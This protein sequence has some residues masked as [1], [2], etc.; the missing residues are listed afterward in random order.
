MGEMATLSLLASYDD[1]I[2]CTN[3]L[4][5]S[6]CEA[7]FMRFALGQLECQRKWLAAENECKRLQ[8][9]LEAA[10]NSRTDL[11]KKLLLARRFLDG[12]KK[13]RYATEQELAAVEKQLGMVRDLVLG[14]DSK[15]PINNETKEKLAFLNHTNRSRSSAVY[16]IGNRESNGKRL[17]T[18][19]EDLDYTGSLLSDLSYSRSDDDLD[20]SLTRSGRPWKKH[21][22]SMPGE[23]PIAAKRRCSNTKSVQLDGMAASPGEQLVATTTVTLSREGPIKASARIE[24]TPHDQK[25]FETPEVPH[26]IEIQPTA[27]PKSSSGESGES[28]ESMIGVPGIGNLQAARSPF[29]SGFTLGKDNINNRG[30]VFAQK[31]IIRPE[32]C[33]PCGKKIKFGKLAAKCRDCRACCHLEC[34]DQLPMPCV[35]VTSTPTR[36]GYVGVISDFTP[37]VAPMIPALIL[38]CIKEIEQR[39]LTEIGLY[40]IPGS[41]RDVKQLKEKFLRSRGAPN[42]TGVEVHVLCGTIKDF[43]RSLREP[44]VT[45]SLWADFV[46]CLEP[47]DLVDRKA[48]LYQVISELPQPNRDTL[49]YLILHLQRI[50]E[51]PECKMPALNL[52]KIFG[53]TLVGY[54]CS[55]PEPMAM[56]NETRQ[57][58]GV[59][60]LMLS[61][62]SSYWASFVNV[63]S[64]YFTQQTPEVHRTPSVDALSHQSSATRGFF[65]PLGSRSFKNR[66]KKYFSKYPEA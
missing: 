4:T 13:K 57:A 62:E 46:R 22:Y 8:Q 31:T 30:H 35:P 24:T 40:R 18:I 43:L 19:T 53:P 34:K 28:E 63:D 56:V 50:S 2:R 32:T 42:L 41:E 36:K 44:L 60:E 37:V 38:H 59:V 21:R 9:E 29:V 66:N 16:S 39:G 17:N 61:T 48:L 45:Q 65:T 20:L 33:E 47:S 52:A 14:D 3:V 12:E 6:G 64:G 15:I 10:N 5:E 25:Y 1:L 7:E 54:S 11:E 23:D 49:A 55:D 58:V 26:R 51:S 27:P